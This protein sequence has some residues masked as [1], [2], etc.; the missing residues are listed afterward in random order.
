ML[1]QEEVARVLKRN[2]WDV[3]VAFF[4]DTTWSLHAE[5]DLAVS[6][7]LDIKGQEDGS[8]EVWAWFDSKDID[9]DLEQEVDDIG[10]L[11]YLLHYYGI[12]A[13]EKATFSPKV[14]KE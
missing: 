10:E 4:E 13:K 11:V 14:A 6:V 12:V 3:R 2:G 1:T 7:D 8:A 9:L 5:R